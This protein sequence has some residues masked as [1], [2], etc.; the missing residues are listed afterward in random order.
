MGV[1]NFDASAYTKMRQRGI[2]Y[3]FN[4]SLVAA[5][6]ANA[7]VRREQPTYQ[8]L[9][10]VTDRKAGSIVSALTETNLNAANPSLPALW[11]KNGS[12]IINFN[13]S[14]INGAAQ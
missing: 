7:T 5:Q 13:P 11:I 4:R 8:S 3:G 14:G 9:G 10:V 12:N 6:D 2:L 1:T